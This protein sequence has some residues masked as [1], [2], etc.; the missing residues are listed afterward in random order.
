MASKTVKEIVIKVSDN[1]T[2]KVTTKEV[3]KLNKAVDKSSA[4]NKKHSKSSQTLNRNM[5]GIS[6]QSS[7]ASKNFSKQAQGMQGVLVPAY[8]EIAA[9]VFALTAAFTAL[10][11]A[12]N[13]SILLQGQETYA[14]MTGKHMGRI[15]KSV[16]IASKHMLDFKEASTSVALA[17]TSGITSKQIVRMTEAAVNSSAALGRSV[18]DTMDRLTRGIVKA[19]PEILDE[20]GVIIRLDK[21]YRDYAESVSKSTTELTEA[22]K[23]SARYTAILGQLETKFGGIA[24]K[25]DPN[26][27]AALSSTVLDII[28]MVSSKGVNYLA[29]PLKFLTDSKT[30]LVA[31]MA[32]ILKSLVGKIFPAFG[33]FGQKIADMPEKMAKKNKLLTE[34]ITKL[35]QQIRGSKVELEK[36]N[37]IIEKTDPKKQTA[38]MIAAAKDKD[39]R[40][41]T[42]LDKAALDRAQKGLIPGGKVKRGIH[43]GA[44]QQDL[45]ILKAQNK[46]LE[47]S[48]TKWEKLDKL[49]KKHIISLKGVQLGYRQMKLGIAKIGA[50]QVELMNMTLGQSILQV[51]RNWVVSSKW[52]VN[53]LNTVK[54]VVSTLTIGVKALGAAINMAFKAFMWITMLLSIGKMIVSIFYDFDTPFK[55]AAEAASTLNEELKETLENLKKRPD[56]ISFDGMASNFADA[57][58]NA[59]FAA[60]LAEEIYNATYKAMKE[61]SGNFSEMDWLDRLM[62]KVK[63]VL[64]IGGFKSTLQE[65]LTTTIELNQISGVPLP[66]GLQLKID[67]QIAS[68]KKG[69]EEERKSIETEN[70]RMQA[71]FQGGQSGSA[72][73]ITNPKLQF[74][75]DASYLGNFKDNELDPFIEIVKSLKTIEADSIKQVIEGLDTTKLSEFLKEELVLQEE[76]AEK[77]KLH[78]TNLRELGQSFNKIAKDQKA[79]SESIVSKTEY[80]EL[81]K[82]QQVLQN[83]FN[84]ESVTSSEKALAGIAAGYIK[85]SEALKDLQ[86]EIKT[87][88]EANAALQR[89]ENLNENIEIAKEQKATSIQNLKRLTEEITSA[90]GELVKSLDVTEY[91][92]VDWIKL[93]EGALK[94]ETKKLGLQDELNF[95]N[96]VGKS[97]FREQAAIKSQLLQYEADVLWKKIQAGELDTAALANVKEQ[98]RIK[99]QLARA[100]GATAYSTLMNKAAISGEPVSLAAQ[101]AAKIE[102][103]ETTFKAE[104]LPTRGGSIKNWLAKEQ[105]IVSLKLEEINERNTLL[106]KIKNTLEA[107]LE[108]IGIERKH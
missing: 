70:D 103:V 101:T 6:R 99:L 7:N 9:R 33:A 1:G 30:L 47:I 27:F 38:G 80:Y 16:Q 15:A 25:I 49:T 39:I 34:G 82:S 20:I 23:A 97:T 96:K 43:R 76:A 87:A 55:K 13:Y 86:E 67:E 61:L 69:L 32:I 84:D 77:T 8:A 108:K 79:Y 2:L 21:V 93:Q 19:E 83:I 10:S 106:N 102:D 18:S 46:E 31:I 41:Y 22:E 91:N 29:G 90:A 58:K 71:M 94:I 60:N 68:N 73:N 45:N 95:L 63:E 56:S 44:T 51:G 62:D 57:L 4:A 3:D 28:N 26:Y 5:K 54:V 40:K 92:I 52:G 105:R 98:L 65:S 24:D 100:A 12:A 81:A 14:Q 72:L 36:F 50:Q 78:A 42:K 11:N 37:K 53:A 107:D 35:R 59:N 74:G 89:G 17:S 48:R 85:E 75:N 64:D 66:K 88:R 104:K